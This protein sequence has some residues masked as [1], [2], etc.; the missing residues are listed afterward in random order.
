MNKLDDFLKKYEEV[1]IYFFNE[2]YEF[3]D[4]K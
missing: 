1:E 4:E 3:D 2:Q